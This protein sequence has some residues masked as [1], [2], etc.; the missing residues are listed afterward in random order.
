MTIKE[1]EYK[2][3]ELVLYVPAAFDKNQNKL[4]YSSVYY[5]FSIFQ[6]FWNVPW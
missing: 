6:L 4:F 3:M 5:V 2:E 1:T